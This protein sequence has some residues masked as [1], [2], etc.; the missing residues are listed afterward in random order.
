MT[1][2]FGSRLMAV[3]VNRPDQA[4]VRAWLEESCAAQGVPVLI[5]DPLTVA[6]VALLFGGPRGNV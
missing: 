1:I 3:D 5:T 2:R 4:L 6:Q